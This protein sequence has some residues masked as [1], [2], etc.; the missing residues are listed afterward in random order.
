[1]EEG[2]VWQRIEMSWSFRFRVHAPILKSFIGCNLLYTVR[3]SQFGPS[4]FCGA[5]LAWGT[6]D[7]VGGE[8]F[9]SGE[10]GVGAQALFDAQELIVFGYAISARG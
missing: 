1:M 3:L 9:E 5:Y 10:N 4:A 7:G 8:G 2:I 6:Q